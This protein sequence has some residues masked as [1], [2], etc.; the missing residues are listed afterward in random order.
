MYEQLADRA[1]RLLAAVANTML[2]ANPEKLKGIE[3]NLSRLVMY[4]IHCVSATRGR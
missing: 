3:G 1:V 4:V 2:K